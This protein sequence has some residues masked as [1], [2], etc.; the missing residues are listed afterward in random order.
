MSAD[1]Q[2]DMMA[3]TKGLPIGRTIG[4]G[5]DGLL[6]ASILALIIAV[7]YAPVRNDTLLLVGGPLLAAV[8]YA[9]LA[10]VFE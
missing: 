5:I 8:A 1:T 9:L 4:R 6:V 2:G 10:P 7:L 3:D